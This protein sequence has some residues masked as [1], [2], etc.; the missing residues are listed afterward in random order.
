MYLAEMLCYADIQ[1]LGRIAK[2]YRCDCNGHSKNELIQSILSKLN[3]RVLFEEQV[4]QLSL[5]DIRFLNSLLF[6]R[7]NAFSQEELMGRARQSSFDAE[8]HEEDRDPKE[9]ITRFQQSGWLFHGNTEKTKYLLQIPEDLKQRFNKL[10]RKRLAQYIEKTEEPEIYRD[11][12]GLMLAD[13]YQLLSQLK[14]QPLPLTAEGFVYKRELQKLL[15]LLFVQE[16]LPS[17]VWR[18]GYGR[19]FKEYP[20]RFSLLY[21]FCFYQGWIEETQDLM[22]LSPQGKE[23]LQHRG[24]I[25]LTE[26]YR[27]WTKLYKGPIRNITSLVHWI[28]ELCREWVPVSALSDALCSLIKPYYNDTALVILQERI[29][30]MMLHIGMLRMGEHEISGKVV[31]M[32]ETGIQLIEG[33]YVSEEQEIDLE[34]TIG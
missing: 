14:E 32:N 23:M 18:F 25:Q 29:L 17:G 16:P 5:T 9:L 34:L 4:K 6:D 33:T 11:E 22:M 10:I 7:R 26:L 19:R 12:Q 27:F 1:E 20:N 24:S 13:V 31:K 15:Q 28:K 3:H 21:D 30:I 2:Y 8:E